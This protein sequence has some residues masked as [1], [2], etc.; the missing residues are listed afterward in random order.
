MTSISGHGLGSLATASAVG[1]TEITDGAIA[2]ADISGTAAIATSKLSGAVTSI[3][4]HGL[5]SL[6][7]LSAVG[8]SEITDGAVSSADIADG[9]IANADIS[10]AAAIATSKLS[11]AVTS[12]ASHGLG[13]AATLNVGTA[14]SNVVQLT[15]A[16]KLPAVDG[17]LLTNIVAT[18]ATKVA[19][20]GDTMTGTLNLA[21]NGLVA[22]T[23]QLVLSGGNVG[24]GT[25]I[26]VAKLEIGGAAGTDG[27][28]Y[29]DGT[30]QT[31]AVP[32]QFFATKAADF[33]IASTD[34]QK[35][36]VVTAAAVATLPAISS[37]SAGAFVTIKRTGD[38][39]VTINRSGSDTIDG[40]TSV[41]LKSNMAFVVLL[42][43]GSAWVVTGSSGTVIN[44]IPLVS[45]SSAY[46]GSV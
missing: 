40:G 5:G 10:N 1:S 31:T 29:P 16:A 35:A 33:S 15:A 13:S 24:I 36:F 21:A 22:G 6:A 28:K 14:A 9:T 43:T 17:S 23:N 44:T 8:S 30:L 32:P 11:G 26:P 3:S 25:T 41:S 39:V 19:K 27:I 4:G 34:M 2:D 46:R 45:Y 7:T 12:I 42:S 37:V 38:G 18:D 20:S